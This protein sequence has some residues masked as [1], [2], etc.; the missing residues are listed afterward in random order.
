M[1]NRNRIIAV[2]GA[3]GQQ[4]NAT[5]RHLLRAGW[6][7][8]ALTRDPSRKTAKELAAAGAEIVVADLDDRQSLER[9]FEGAHGVFGVQPMWGAQMDRELAQGKAVADA[10]HGARVAHFV[11][12]SVL[13]SGSPTGVPHFDSKTA[14]EAHARGLGLTMTIIKPAFFMDN[15]I[16]ISDWR[17]ALRA[18]RLVISMKPDVALDLIAVDDIGALAAVVFDAPERF[19]GA[20]L[21]LAGDRMTAP[22]MARVIGDATLREIAFA[23]FPIEE[24]RRYSEEMAVMFEW[25]GT[26]RPTVDI[27]ACRRLVPGLKTFAAWVSQNRWE[28]MA[29]AG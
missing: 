1:A 17:N 22:E 3:T 26:A 11:Y 10:A 5:A 28:W 7:V 20:T 27:A 13:Y 2:T 19:I 18:G 4:G 8:R 16:A 12:T 6:R 29:A 21:P 25:F 9:A 15:F 24:L 23:P 14:L